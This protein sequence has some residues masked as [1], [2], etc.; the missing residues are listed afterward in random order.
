MASIHLKKR[1]KEEKAP[2]P[3]H[4]KFKLMQPHV[5]ELYELCVVNTPTSQHKS[6]ILPT[7]SNTKNKGYEQ[8]KNKK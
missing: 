3:K 8:K 5:L 7:E 4:L 2:S 1:R 6:T